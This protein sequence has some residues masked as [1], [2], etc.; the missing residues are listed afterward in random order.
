[1]PLRPEMPQQDPKERVK[2]F[3]EVTSG[4]TK[5]DTIAEAMRCIQCKKPTCVAGCPVEID[6]P[7]F[8]ALIA[9]KDIEGA[10]KKIKEK[11]NLPAIC[12]RVCP[13]ETQCEEVCILGRKKEPIAIGRLE[14]FAADHEIRQVRDKK[15]KIQQ[16]KKGTKA[17]VAIVGA[18]PSGLTCASDLARMGYQVKVF[19]SLHETGGVLSYGIPEFRLPKEIV[20][21]EVEG[22]KK[23]GVEIET[24][25]LVGRTITIEELLE[26]GYK[27]FFIGSGAGLPRFQ[28]IPGE[29][30]NG[31]YSANE[32]LV[33]VNLMKAYK[34][35]EYIT[36]VKIGKSVAVIGGGNVAMDSARASLRLGSNKVTIV[37]RRSEKEM[38]ARVE[39]VE[40]AKEEG[41][42]FEFLTN[43]TQIIGDK[44]GVKQ[45]E[46]IKMELGEPDESGRRRPVPI[47]GSEFKI[48]VD[49]V[50]VAIGNSPNP[51]IPQTVKGLKTEK[52]GGII[53]NEEGQS[54]IP[55]IFAGG[56]IVTGAATVIEAMGAGKRA[57]R[58]MDKYLS[59]KK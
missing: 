34:F 20:K 48:N 46:C 27:A 12:G 47:E 5:E 52:W 45:M 50:I 59:N 4:Y 1:M 35:P 8:L 54:S 25:V 24:N 14:R 15:K 23:L 44:S 19:E 39:E 29:S 38:P 43:P 3:S 51:L 16:K 32:F 7:A 31:V 26:D 11:N 53:V 30:L 22:I 57:A 40:H 42:K 17:K 2:N 36:P 6:I 37:Y 9:D 56:D 10:I 41:V 55:Y 18:G 33:R 13:Q 49:I 21:F 28:R 58:A